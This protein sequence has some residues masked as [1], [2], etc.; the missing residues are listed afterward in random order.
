MLFSSVVFLFYFLPL[1]LGLYYILRF[2]VTLK[3]MLLLVASLF[4]YAWG[5]PWFVLIM[6]AS[7]CFNYVFALLVD[8]FR[9]RRKAAYTI[10]TLMLIVNLGMLFVFKYLAFALRIVNENTS[11]GLSIPNI[12]LPLGI[13]FFTFHGISYVIDVYRGHGAVQ[14]NLFYVALYISF[15]PQLVAGP[16]LRYNTIADQMVNRKE[17]WDKFAVGCCRFIVGL[18]K[19]V[20][21]SNSM[22]IVADH[23][24]SM[25]GTSEVSSS[26]AWLGAIAYTLQIYFDFSGYSDMAIGLAL[27]FGFKFEE[28]FRYPYISRSITEFWRRW[29]ISLGTWFKEYVYFPLGGSRVTNKDKMIRNLLIVWGLT[30]VWHGAEW[31]FVVWGLINFAFIALE[32]IFSFDKGTRFIPLRHLY[33]M[34]I[35]VIGWVIFRSPDLLQAGHY[36]G[37]MFGLYGNGFWSNTTGMFLKE[38]AFF[39]ILGILFCMPIATRMNKLMVDGARF[40]KPLELVYPLTIILLFL[41]CVSY[42][43]KG[44]YNP[45]IY[46]NF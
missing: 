15:F 8:K 39:F 20:L 12:A 4:F 19:K 37:N 44:T 41:V 32:K 6:L 11:F 43:V 27:M 34:F 35:V 25:G 45:F 14:K 18:G 2:S 24:F 7:I 40:R 29:H 1:V 28:N 5:E 10:I 9:E 31:T 16:I 42:L 36:L 46:F 38:Y 22:A 30:G 3:N 33:A 13:S 26:L 21:L 23:I 17:S